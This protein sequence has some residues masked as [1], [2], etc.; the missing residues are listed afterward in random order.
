MVA[1][2]ERSKVYAPSC[3]DYGHDGER[4]TF[5][6]LGGG[7]SLLAERHIEFLRS[8]EELVPGGLDISVLVA[9]QEVEDAEIV[10]SVGVTPAQFSERVADTLLATRARVAPYGWCADFMTNTIPGL[11]AAEHE[12]MQELLT[13]SKYRQQLTTDAMGRTELYRSINPRMTS[14]EMLRRT[15]RVA[16]QYLALGVCAAKRNV[17]VCN[18]STVNLSWY[19]RT[20]VGLLHNPVCIYG[21]GA[22]KEV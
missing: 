4:Y 2:E 15:A 12:R 7:V 6:G 9:N 20:E 8:L 17:V 19:K 10:R 3:P 18:H 13:D 5:K 1:S 22:L 14:E 11:L 16:A 21:R